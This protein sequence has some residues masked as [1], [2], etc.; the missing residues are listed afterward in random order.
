[1]LKYFFAITF[2]LF[3]L[4]FHAQ[5]FKAGDI[6]FKWLSG[7]TYE[8]TM[9]L[10]SNIPTQDKW[11]YDSLCFGDGSNVLMPRTNGSLGACSP[12]HD[13]VSISPTIKYSEYKITHTY[14]GPGTYAFC[15][16][17]WNRESGV[18]NIPNSVNQKAYLNAELK[19]N[20]F[21]GANS[22]PTFSNIPV[23]YACNNTPLTYNLGASDINNDSL[24]FKLELSK[25]AVGVI[26]PGATLPIPN[27]SI[28]NLTGDISWNNPQMAGTYNFVI[29][30]EEWRNSG[31]IPKQVGFVERETQFIIEACTGIDDRNFDNRIS[32]VPNPTNDKIEITIKSA[33]SDNFTLTITDIT[34]RIIETYSDKLFNDSGTTLIDMSG[35]ANGVYFIQ[36]Q[37]NS[38]LITKKIIKQ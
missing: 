2:S 23:Y 25:M 7:N 17:E 30:I 28:N 38:Q 15:H 33:I 22:N 12:A 26:V 24:S 34:G 20:T 9:E 4:K 11:C 35:L 31:G 27:F 13:G 19:I 5:H 18:I 14:P 3:S 6:L 32:I 37:N 21:S 16:R 36:L 8:I 10:Y 29:K 1:M